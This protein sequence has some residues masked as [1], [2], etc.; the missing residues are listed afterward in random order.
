[1]GLKDLLL[2]QGWAGKTI[3][4]SETIELLNPIIRT[5]NE[6]MQCLNALSAASTDADQRVRLEASL[7]TLRMDIG[8]LCETVFSCGGIAYSG[9]DLSPSDFAEATGAQVVALEQVL[10]GQLADQQKIEHQMRTRAIL[11]VLEEN[12]RSRKNSLRGLGS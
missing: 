3:G 10:A 12:Q 8:K 4:R 2:K 6:L 11:G 1:M 9:T 5:K 7:R